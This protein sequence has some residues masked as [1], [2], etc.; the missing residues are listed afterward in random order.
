LPDE[1]P[2]SELLILDGFSA[3]DT[4]FVDTG[5]LSAVSASLAVFFVSKIAG[6]I[7]FLLLGIA[8][9]DGP[10]HEIIALL[11]Y[12]YFPLV[13]SIFLVNRA[14][15]RSVLMHFYVYGRACRPRQR[16]H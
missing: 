10:A 11:Q 2:S 6:L 7:V 5:H 4:T 15:R 13:I 14:I 3:A 1:T 12:M 9:V 8:F 16:W